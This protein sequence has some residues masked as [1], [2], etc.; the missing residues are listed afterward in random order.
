[1]SENTDTD[2][3]QDESKLVAFVEFLEDHPP[4]Q[5]IDVS[6]VAVRY[7]TVSG[8]YYELN[9]PDIQLHCTNEDC[10]GTRFHRC[11]DDARTILSDESMKNFYMTYQ[12]SN[13]RVNKKVFSMAIV[14]LGDGTYNGKCFKFG[15]APTFGPPTPARLIS[16]I[17]PDRDLFLKG[18][19]CENQG[20]GIGAFIYYRRVVENQKDRILNQII[21][22]SEKI[23]APKENVDVL[24]NAVKETQFSRALDMSKDALPESLLI[25]GHSPLKLLHSALSEGVHALND[26][27]CLAIA[28]SIRVILAELSDKLSQ[29]LKDNVAIEHA[30]TTLM[31]LKK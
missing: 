21:R 19:R 6:D 7:T 9:K 29:A 26:D 1:M 15:E 14:M 27:D 16:L 18:R 23:G 10:N 5:I 12:C 2:D 31:N 24:K 17:G 8:H 20:L 28:N 22:V 3:K 4:S 13:C 25:N 30:L 11:I